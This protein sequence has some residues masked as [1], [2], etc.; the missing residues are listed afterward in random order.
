MVLGRDIKHVTNDVRGD[1]L[2]L[3]NASGPIFSTTAP[4]T[5]N[6]DVESFAVR[7]SLD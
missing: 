6:D 4:T 1:N 7:R 2:S 5:E 3:T